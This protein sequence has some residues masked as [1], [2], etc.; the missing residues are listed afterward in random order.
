M[1]G[2][3]VTL[4]GS[5]ATGLWSGSANTPCGPM[6]FQF[7]YCHNTD[8]VTPFRFRLEVAR[9]GRDNYM[10]GPSGN[11]TTSP[12]RIEFHSLWSPPGCP[13]CDPVSGYFNATFIFATLIVS[14]CRRSR[15]RFAVD[16][17]IVLRHCLPAP[18][19]VGTKEPA[20]QCDRRSP[21]HRAS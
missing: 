1:N 3:T 4:T 18:P 21:R 12:L 11:P 10:A 9:S 20:N 5:A 17:G 16:E 6:L 2:T 14:F 8:I 15:Q 13:N 19:R 7:F